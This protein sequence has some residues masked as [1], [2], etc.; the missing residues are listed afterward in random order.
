MVL[1][2]IRRR[3]Q[4]RGQ[5]DR[6][7]LSRW[8]KRPRTW[9][10]LTRQSVSACVRGRICLA[11]TCAASR[12]HPG[13]CFRLAAVRRHT[14]VVR[15]ERADV[16]LRAKMRS[17]HYMSTTTFE[18][19]R[20]KALTEGSNGGGIGAGGD[21]HLERHGVGRTCVAVGCATGG[22]ERSESSTR[23]VTCQV[24]GGPDQPA[25]LNERRWSGRCRRI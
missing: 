10:L 7:C 3:K 13:G 8:L 11:A 23:N 2:S 19:S 16:C 15:A 9:G 20:A 17:A 24:T 6:L 21:P 1:R 12:K 4:R 5:A 18:D 14:G 22:G 25:F